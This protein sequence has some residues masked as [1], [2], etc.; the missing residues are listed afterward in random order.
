[1]AVVL[2]TAALLSSG[3]GNA[4]GGTR[5]GGGS[6]IIHP[7]AATR[8]GVASGGLASA[9]AV[10]RRKHKKPKPYTSPSGLFIQ[11]R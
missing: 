8:D 7:A 3:H 6:G 9:D 1:M 10:G 4:S 11:V 5:S 2:A